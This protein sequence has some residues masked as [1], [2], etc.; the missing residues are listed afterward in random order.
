MSFQD[1][2]QQPVEK[3][4][5]IIISSTSRLEDARV[6]AYKKYYQALGDNILTMNAYANTNYLPTSTTT[7]QE[8]TDFLN[9]SKHT[10]NITLGF[11]E[12]YI[13]L[14]MLFVIDPKHDFIL[15]KSDANKS[16][17]PRFD[18]TNNFTKTKRKEIMRKI[19]KLLRMYDNRLSQEYEERK[20]YRDAGD[21][22]VNFNKSTADPRVLTT[23]FSL[24]N[25][26]KFRD[27]L[28]I[29]LGSNPNRGSI[30]LGEKN[31]KFED[32]HKDW[33][34]KL[35]NNLPYIPTATTKALT[36]NASTTGND[37]VKKAAATAAANMEMATRILE[38]YR[39]TRKR[40]EDITSNP[41]SINKRRCA[42]L[43][44]P[45]Y[46][47]YSLPDPKTFLRR[48]KFRVSLPETP[49]SGGNKTDIIDSIFEGKETT[50]TLGESCKG[51]GFSFI[52]GAE[53]GICSSLENIANIYNKN[54]I[55]STSNFLF[56]NLDGHGPGH[57][58]VVLNDTIVYVPSPRCH[59]V[60][61]ILIYTHYYVYNGMSIIQLKNVARNGAKYYFVQQK[62]LEDINS[63]LGGNAQSNQKWY[64]DADKKQRFREYLQNEH[65]ITQDCFDA[66]FEDWK[67]IAKSSNWGR[68]IKNYIECVLGIQ[69]SKRSGSLPLVRLLPAIATKT[70]NNLYEIKYTGMDSYIKVRNKEACTPPPTSGMKKIVEPGTVLKNVSAAELSVSINPKLPGGFEIGNTDI[71]FNCRENRPSGNSMQDIYTR[72]VSYFE[73]DNATTDKEKIFFNTELHRT[74]PYIDGKTYE[75]VY[76]VEFIRDGQKIAAGLQL[77]M[78]GKVEPHDGVNYK[79]T[80]H[81]GGIFIIRKTQPLRSVSKHKFLIAD[82]DDPLLPRKEMAVQVNS[83]TKIIAPSSSSPTRDGSMH[84]WA[85]KH[86]SARVRKEENLSLNA[87]RTKEASTAYYGSTYS[88]DLI[89]TSRKA[90]CDFGQSLNMYLKTGG[91]ICTNETNFGKHILKGSP[92]IIVPDT[93]INDIAG[94]KLSIK[95]P[96]EDL[97]V[98]PTLVDPMNNAKLDFPVVSIHNDRP[99]VVAAGLLLKTNHYKLFMQGRA[100]YNVINLMAHTCYPNGSTYVFC[101]QMG[102]LTSEYFKD[103]EYDVKGKRTLTATSTGRTSS[104]AP[105]RQ[106]FNG[107]GKNI[108][109]TGGAKVQELLN[110][111]NCDLYCLYQKE[112][113]ICDTFFMGISVFKYN[114]N[115]V[116]IYNSYLRYLLDRADKFLLSSDLNACA[117]LVS[118]IVAMEEGVT[119]PGEIPVDS[120]SKSV[121]KWHNY[122]KIINSLPYD[123]EILSF[124]KINLN[125]VNINDEGSIIGYTKKM[126]ENYNFVLKTMQDNININ[127]YILGSGKNK[128]IEK[129]K[130]LESTNEMLRQAQ[131]QLNDAARRLAE[132]ERTREP[133]PSAAPPQDPTEVDNRILTDYN[134]DARNP[135]AP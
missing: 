30:T 132:D 57:T 80:Q 126:E 95:F 27:S 74:Y 102:N 108:N 44:A 53:S 131:K 118:V 90:M 135:F 73:Y 65:N 78:P 4:N 38:L 113:E 5:E 88:C 41:S 86:F 119:I 68:N 82:I 25:F 130:E 81:G 75:N 12:Y 21:A 29:N 134:P 9:R 89:N 123:K 72:F 39:A 28:Y 15:T 14:E 10:S 106:R 3:I 133:K 97:V 77:N 36:A 69:K 16:H 116:K 129:N 32:W 34:I 128:L 59:T 40:L 85:D 13:F 110:D 127:K 105:K 63:K 31:S 7:Q 125:N 104:A 91:Y 115:S 60:Y 55:A 61:I 37:N 54:G 33:L 52:D 6:T 56:C 112:K 46:D 67:E 111:E 109:Q 124:F 83:E 19:D 71:T 20:I 84:Y 8:Q 99:A 122:R 58:G 96:G 50:K 42:Y 23:N 26:E 66:A 117:A 100:D 43:N 62:I 107:G 87:I 2:Y 121:K 93:G 11:E 51:N 70:N 79:F 103:I 48:K 45:S 17:F 76:I 1:K 18:G 114:T 35:M 24:G 94:K 120:S 92:Q 22:P 47:A 64:D 98:S 49:S 101:N